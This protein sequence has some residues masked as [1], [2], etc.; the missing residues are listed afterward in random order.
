MTERRGPIGLSEEQA[1]LLESAAKFCA[2]KSPIDAVRRL[3]DDEL[4]YD[5]AVFGEIAELGWLGIAIP[6]EWGGAGLE[7][8]EVVPVV[9]HMGRHLMGGP[10]VSTTLAAQLL[11]AA[12]T[13]A[14]QREV[15]PQLA[16][17]TPATLALSEPHADFDPTHVE[18]TATREG[19]R[20][21]LSGAKCLVLDAH[22]AKWMLVSVRLGGEIALV[23][24]DADAI[25]ACKSRR[26]IVIDETR[27][28]FRLDLD[29]VSLPASSLLDPARSAAGLARTELAGA[30]LAS[31]EM[32]GGGTSC[33]AYTVR[34]LNARKQFGRPIGAYQALKHTT[35]DAHLRLEQARS[36]LYA[37]AHC[38]DKTEDREGEIAVRMAK[39]WTGPALAF[40]ADR[41][42]QFHGGYGF[43]YECDAQ[44]YRRRALWGETQYGD[45]IHQRRLLAGLIL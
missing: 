4:G 41:S 16:A 33:I 1:E 23:L 31:A 14:Q 38:F 44:L 36:H 26:E 3:I 32:C 11:L 10:F 2:D 20:L 30:L 28:S 45:A 34:Y 13:E 21:V 6:E 29:G 18:S 22:V 39:A 37:A 35:V 8:A 7:L 43:T 17:G 25:G 19:D 24:L 9:E 42:I 27:R 40:A 15:L 5:P 12:G